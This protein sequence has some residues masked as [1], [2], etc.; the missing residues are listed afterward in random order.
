MIRSTFEWNATCSLT[1]CVKH[2]LIQRLSS[3]VAIRFLGQDEH[4]KAFFCF[5]KW[6]CFV[7]SRILLFLKKNFD[8][9]L[10]SASHQWLFCLLAAEHRHR[11]FHLFLIPWHHLEESLCCY[12]ANRPANTQLCIDRNQRTKHSLHHLRQ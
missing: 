2:W 9:Y 1:L 7:Y 8:E 12:K 6:T 10:W 11:S 4:M 3:I 5:S